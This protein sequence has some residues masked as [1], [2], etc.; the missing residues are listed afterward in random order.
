MKERDRGM[1]YDEQAGDIKIMCS[2]PSASG[3]NTRDKVF[4]K[5]CL[6]RVNTKVQ[7]R[8]MLVSKKSSGG[9]VKANNG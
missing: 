9:V 2:G 5:G 4:D 3:M 1:R 7:S 8:A 6:Y